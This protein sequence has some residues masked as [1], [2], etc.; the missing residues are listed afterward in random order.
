MATTP[1]SAPA[2]HDFILVIDLECTCSRHDAPASDQIAPEAMEVIE[3]GAAWSTIYGDVVDTFSRIA[4]PTERPL[5]TPFAT[6]ITGIAQTTVDAAQPLSH[7]LYEFDLWLQPTLQ[8]FRTCW[9]S[10]GAFDARHLG[11]ECARKDLACQL[12][13]LPHVNLKAEFARRRRI[14]QVGM[15][16][17]LKIVGH[18]HQ[19]AHHRG[20]DDALNICRLVP[21]SLPRT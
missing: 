14:R 1:V 13:A 19:G 7:V 17:A 15:R 20:L 8:A 2:S 4:R 9:G 12:L 10:W 21:H 16:S 3:I 6:E 11:R 18:E 5:L